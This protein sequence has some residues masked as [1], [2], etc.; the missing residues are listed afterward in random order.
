MHNF[1]DLS[2]GAKILLFAVSLVVLAEGAFLYY[3]QTKPVINSCQ[4]MISEWEKANPET[5]KAKEAYTGP[6][7]AVNYDS[8]KWPQAALL[9]EVID[10]AVA[11]GPNFAG[12]F[13]MLDWD[14]G[15]NCKRHAIVDVVTGNIMAF[16][17][18]SELGLR[19][20]IESSL[21]V[22][23]PV[24][25]VPDLGEV[26]GLDFEKKRLWFNT[27]REYYELSEEGTKV[28]V[29]RLCIENTYDSQF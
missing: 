28:A 6:I 10:E 13:V 27:P 1:F 7:A 8:E 5:A 14:C 29:R 20:S 23:N 3:L 24:G 17:I 22:T 12:H 4:Y 26:A 16:G 9:K 2:K 18:P 11:K 21:F 19:Y 25:T 15:E